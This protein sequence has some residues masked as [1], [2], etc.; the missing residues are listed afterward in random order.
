MAESPDKQQLIGDL[1]KTQAAY[2][3]LLGSLSAEDWNK[4]SGNPD[5]TVREAMWHM[6]WSVGWL[7]GSID[8]VKDGKDFNP[9]GFILEPA[10][11]FAIW[12]LALRATPERAA[13]KYDEGHEALV[14]R[15][16]AVEDAD[17]ALTISLLG[18]TRNIEWF[19]RQP[20][21]HFEE[22]SADVRAALT[23]A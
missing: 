3:D 14:K 7:G 2:H 13:A 19:A 22:H 11:R 20:P 10:R 9:P 16:N 5:L 17:W 18:E 4:E 23:S 8:R 1:E 12:W 15:L 6:A 21:E